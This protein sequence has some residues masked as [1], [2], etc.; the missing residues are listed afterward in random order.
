MAPTAPLSADKLYRRVDPQSL[1]FDTTNELTELDDSFGQQ[2]AVEAVEF[3]IGIRRD[4]YNMFALGPTGMGKS[5]L[6]AALGHQHEHVHLPADV[7]RRERLE[8]ANGKPRDERA[9]HPLHEVAGQVAAHAAV[10]TVGGGATTTAAATGGSGA[11]TGRVTIAT[12]ASTSKVSST[13]PRA[14]HLIDDGSQDRMNPIGY[15]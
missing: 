9:E 3:G 2:R 11:L 12:T 10:V 5:W 8:P 7:R 1:G 14:S 4:G 15:G 6:A 13:S